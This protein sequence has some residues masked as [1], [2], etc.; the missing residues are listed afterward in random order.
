MTNH[1]R[2]QLGQAEQIAT[3]SLAEAKVQTC[4]D[5]RPVPVV[6]GH[7]ALT[8]EPLRASAAQVYALLGETMFSLPESESRRV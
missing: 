4:E 2:E 7:M 5:G 1:S 3:T 6:L 8:I